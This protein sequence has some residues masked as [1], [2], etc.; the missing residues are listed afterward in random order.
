MSASRTKETSAN[1]KLAEEE[2]GSK[3]DRH[4]MSEIDNA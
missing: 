2:I 4:K 1:R 3:H